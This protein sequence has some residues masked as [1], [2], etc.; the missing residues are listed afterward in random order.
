MLISRG[1]SAIGFVLIVAMPAAAVDRT[2][3]VTTGDWFTEVNWNPAG[4][5][6]AGDTAIIPSGRTAQLNAAATVAGLS[7]AGTLTGTGTLTVTGAT[8]WT[9]G[10]MSGSGT[11]VA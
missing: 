1:L 2:F 3:L 6:E 5:P 8:T 10:T 11:T 7:L 4:V 9:S